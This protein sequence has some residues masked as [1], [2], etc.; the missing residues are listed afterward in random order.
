MLR[1]PVIRNILITLNRNKFKHSNAIKQWNGYTTI[2]YYRIYCTRYTKRNQHTM[3]SQDVL[4]KPTPSVS[5]TIHSSS[6]K[7]NFWGQDRS[8][9]PPNWLLPPPKR[10]LLPGGRFQLQQRGWCGLSG[11]EQ[12]WTKATKVLRNLLSNELTQPRFDLQWILEYWE[13][14]KKIQ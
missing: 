12:L 4:Q 9:R 5:N 10:W 14:E 7:N 6:N 8:S 1:G 2:G 13:S 11:S 3:K